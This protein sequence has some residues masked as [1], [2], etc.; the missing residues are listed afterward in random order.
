MK[1]QLILTF[2]ISMIFT[3]TI[4]TTEDLQYDINGTYKMYNFSSPQG[5][6][7]LTGQIGG[8]YVFD[9]SEGVTS[10]TIDI[11]YVEINDGDHGG[12]FSDATVAERKKRPILAKIFSLS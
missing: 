12:D 9:F 11:E 4:I 1:L 7:G 10:D 5:V 3:Q 6:I 2:S 8:P